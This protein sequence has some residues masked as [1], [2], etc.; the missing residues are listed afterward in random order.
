MSRELIAKNCESKSP[1]VPDVIN[2]HHEPSSDKKTGDEPEED[3]RC[4]CTLL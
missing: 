2:E 1:L 3:K 4:S